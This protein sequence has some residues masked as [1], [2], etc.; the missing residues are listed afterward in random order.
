[1][2][3]MWLQILLF[4]RLSY[5]NVFQHF[6]L[7]KDAFEYNFQYF[8][9]EIFGFLSIKKT[10]IKVINLFVVVFFFLTIWTNAVKNE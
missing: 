4:I 6:T 9:A 2:I 8:V 3:L 10:R 7:Y 1:M 5:L